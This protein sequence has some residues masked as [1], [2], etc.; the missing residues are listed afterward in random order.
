MSTLAERIAAKKAAATAVSQPP[1][2]TMEQAVAAGDAI[3]AAE[4]AQPAKPL[5]FAEKLALKRAAESAIPVPNMPS[6]APAV[7]VSQ[8][9]EQ[10]VSPIAATEPEPEAPVDTSKMSFAEKLA[11]KKASIGAV[12]Q[13]PAAQKQAVSTREF[14]ID[15]ERLPEDS[16]VAQALMDISKRIFDLEELMDEDLSRSMSEL[17]DAL[18]KN[19]AASELILDEDVGKMVSSLRRM[20]HLSTVGKEKKPAGSKTKPKA[21]EVALTPEQLAQAWDEL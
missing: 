8:P 14:S 20:R 21:K 16:E 11:L 12:Q 18:R 6:Q 1:V 9:A 2:P 19:P 17:K 10:K 13:G 4:Q 7:A 15:P 5:T 3:I